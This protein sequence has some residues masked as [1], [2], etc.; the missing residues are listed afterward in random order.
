MQAARLSGR[1]KMT[2]GV[3]ESSQSTGPMCPNTATSE[4][5]TSP[6]L[7]DLT[8]SPGGGRV[9]HARLPE[10]N[11]D[12]KTHDG[13]GLSSSEPFAYYDPDTSSLKTCQGCFDGHSQTYSGTW[14][15]AGMMRNGQVYQRR[16]LAPRISVRGF[17]SWPTPSASDKLRTRFSVASHILCAANYKRR[18]RHKTRDLLLE[19]ADEFSSFPTA[20]MAEWLMGYPETWTDLADSVIV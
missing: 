17:G 8:S 3:D 16:R 19:I 15:S 6:V 9:N 5:L 11:L 18:G 12:S 13:S 7:S 1:W 2:N 20:E 14:P 4:R 10:S